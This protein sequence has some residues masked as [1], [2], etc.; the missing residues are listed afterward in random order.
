LRGYL[1]EGD[2]G[3]LQ[4]SGAQGAEGQVQF[5]ALF[6]LAVDLSDLA[7]AGATDDTKVL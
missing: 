5:V 4:A 6:A 1:P 2:F 7:G 3:Y